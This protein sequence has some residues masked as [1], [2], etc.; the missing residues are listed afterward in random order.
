MPS[1]SRGIKN[2]E[3]IKSARKRMEKLDEYLDQLDRDDEKKAVVEEEPVAP[4]KKKGR[5]KNGMSAEQKEL[6]KLHAYVA[7]EERDFPSYDHLPVAQQGKRLAVWNK[8][9]AR[10]KA[11]VASGVSA[12]GVPKNFFS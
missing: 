4:K 3:K 10:A 7:K 5:K 9:I 11:L 12:R 2:L 1:V 6:K 8:N